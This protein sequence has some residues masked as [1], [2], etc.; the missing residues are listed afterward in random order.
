[1]EIFQKIKARLWLVWHYKIVNVYI[2][3]IIFEHPGNE[4][5]EGL[6]IIQADDKKMVIDFTSPKFEAY[7]F[8]ILF[9]SMIVFLLYQSFICEELLFLLIA[10]PILIPSSLWVV[11]NLYNPPRKV[12]FHRKEGVVEVPAPWLKGW[13]P[14]NTIFLDFQT[15]DLP[16]TGMGRKIKYPDNQF[17]LLDMQGNNDDKVLSLLFWYMDPNRPLPPGKIFDPYRQADFKRRKAEGFPQPLVE[18]WIKT[19]EDT[20]EQQQERDAVWQRPLR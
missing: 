5:Y 7:F 8:G 11:K 15:L 3:K 9:G 14:K 13:N 4:P 20:K 1:M 12:T 10:S 6:K 16:M 18:S 2:A 17:F 19:P